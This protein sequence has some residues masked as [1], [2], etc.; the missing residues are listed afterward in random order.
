MFRREAHV[1]EVQVEG[2][3]GRLAIF[4]RPPAVRLFMNLECC[5][6]NDLS[7]ILL[8]SAVLVDSPSLDGGT[9]RMWTVVRPRWLGLTPPATAFLIR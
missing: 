8:L 2:L 7:V 5:D 3:A 9:P 6:H 1:N 4:G